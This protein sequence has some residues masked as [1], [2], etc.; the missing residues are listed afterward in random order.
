MDLG[1][2]AFVDRTGLT[3]SRDSPGSSSLRTAIAGHQLPAVR[4]KLQVSATAGSWCS[5]QAFVVSSLIARRGGQI[6]GPS[7]AGAPGG[8]ELVAPLVLCFGHLAVAMRVVDTWRLALVTAGRAR[9]CRRSTHCARLAQSWCAGVS[10]PWQASTSKRPSTLSNLAKSEVSMCRLP[11]GTSSTTGWL[12]SAGLSAARLLDTPPFQSGVH[13][14]PAASCACLR[15]SLCCTYPP[16][17]VHSAASQSVLVQS[18]LVRG[19]FDATP[20]SCRGMMVRWQHGELR[21]SLAS[22]QQEPLA[23]TGLAGARLIQPIRTCIHSI[24]LPQ[25]ASG[26][27]GCW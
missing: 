14:E 16:H 5:K 1:K 2:D 23:G 25:P 6:L 13:A 15:P 9:L 22:T 10:T 12:S 21:G 17:R 24:P 11:C 26:R 19:W 18:V 4:E 8:P 7:F 20:W 3:G 27:R